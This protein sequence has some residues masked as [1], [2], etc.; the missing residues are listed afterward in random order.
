MRAGGPT[1]KCKP[2]NRFFAAPSGP[3]PW[4][5]ANVAVSTPDTASPSRQSPSS[6][7]QGVSEEVPLQAA[8][9]DPMP[10]LAPDMMPVREQ[11]LVSPIPALE[12][13]GMLQPDTPNASPLRERPII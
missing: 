4:G 5:G 11:A 6:S 13:S 10:H 8:I 9:A 1:G 3:N 7:I 12:K 2:L